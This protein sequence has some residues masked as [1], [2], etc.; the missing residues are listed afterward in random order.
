MSYRVSL[1][2]SDPDVLDRIAAGLEEALEIGSRDGDR[3]RVVVGMK[4]QAVRGFE[5][6]V[7]DDTDGVFVI[8]NQSEGRHG[9]GRDAQMRHHPLGRRETEL[10]VANLI[11]DRPQFRSLSRDEDHQIMAVAL[12]VAQKQIL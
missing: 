2:G 12:L 4:R 5:V 3:L 8:V 11:R 1:R 10:A 9:T 6:A 7:K